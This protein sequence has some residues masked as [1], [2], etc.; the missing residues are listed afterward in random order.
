MRT[1]TGNAAALIVSRRSTTFAINRATAL[2]ATPTIKRTT[3]RTVSLDP[4]VNGAAVA[5]SVGEL[6][7]APRSVGPA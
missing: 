6:T 7:A 2:V 4:F 5:R 1:T 3:M